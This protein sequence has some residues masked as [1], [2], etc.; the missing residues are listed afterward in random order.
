MA[1]VVEDVRSFDPVS[2]VR[3]VGL[4]PED[5]YGFLP[6]E[7][8]DITPYLYLYRDRPEYEQRRATLPISQPVK[9][10]G[11]IRI[12]PAQQ[13]EMDMDRD[14]PG[15]AE[16]G[17]GEVIAAAQQLA[18]AYGGGQTPSGPAAAPDPELLGRLAKLRSSGAIDDQEYSR[19]LAEATNAPAAPGPGPASGDP[20]G[21]AEEAPAAAGA[22]VAQRLY[23]GMR[24]R[25]S[26]RQ[27]NHFM[28]RY[29][30][31][32]SLRS[33]DVYGVL[34]RTTRYSSS[35]DG[36]DTKEWDDFWIVYRDRPEYAQGRE[37]WAEEMNKD[38]K[39]PD[40]V[41][42]PGVGTAPGIAYDGAK[43][44][45]EKD[46]WPRHTLV[47]RQRG[48]DLGDSLRE[49]IGKWGYEPEDSLGFCPNFP[50]RSIY[51][52]WRKR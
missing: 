13:V 9:G 3:A 29:R 19:L 43:L 4:Q 21:A 47:V 26:T 20:G 50:N 44:K 40:T 45:V 24:M 35:G 33:E 15:G 31:A 5:C 23:P 32:L 46:R 12:E 25:S 36:S 49:K 51:F 28:P 48:E 8:D 27:L 6:I 11:P 2:Y 39:W 41:V 34:P 17:L 14:L 38:G 30:E 16:G 22:I 10:F 42:S 52:A 7:H 18:E 37:A 1:E